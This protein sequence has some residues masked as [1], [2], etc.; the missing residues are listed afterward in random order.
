[1]LL[2]N[3]GMKKLILVLCIILSG[4]LCFSQ[5]KIFKAI[6]DGDN[7]FVIEYISKGKDLNVLYKA[8]A[9]DGYSQKKISYSFEVLEY[10]ANQGDEKI[11]K[12]LLNS[13]NR[14]NNFQSSLNKAFASS[15]S[16]GNM[17]VIKLLLDAGADVNSVCQICYGQTAIQTALEYASFDL[18]NYL[19]QNGANLNVQNNFGRTLLHSVAHTGNIEIAKQL[20]EKG[21]DINSRDVDGA[22]PLIYA[23]SNGDPVMFK[24]LVEKGATIAIKENDGTDVLMNAVVKG[25]L[26]IVNFLLDKRCD[27]N[28]M[29]D[30]KNTPLIFATTEKQFSIAELLISRGADVNIMNSKGETALIWAI[31]NDDVKIAQLLIDKGADLKNMDYLKQAKKYIKDQT[32]IKYL[33]EKIKKTGK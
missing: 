6:Q 9:V 21:L 11:V 24:L 10:A 23:A 22:T 17:A 30:D 4:Q 25:N 8:T 5:S 28:I 31:W 12:L 13:K 2:K 32:F 27:I 1:M 26:D 3:S 20:L 15:I 29:N 33:E 7:E 18:Y 14:F 19:L 16:N